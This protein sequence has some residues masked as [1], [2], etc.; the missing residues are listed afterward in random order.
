MEVPP[1]GALDRTTDFKTATPTVHPV[2][3]QHTRVS[4]QGQQWSKES[5]ADA[6]SV[7]CSNEISDE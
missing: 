6:G 7:W 5:A 1:P 2:K 4:S 3:S